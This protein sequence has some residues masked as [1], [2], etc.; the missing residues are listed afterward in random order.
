[1]TNHDEINWGILQSLLYDEDKWILS[2]L[3]H[4]KMPTLRC[5][6]TLQSSNPKITNAYHAYLR[7]IVLCV[8]NMRSN[9][10]EAFL[11]NIIFIDTGETVIIISFFSFKSDT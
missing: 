8:Q 11:G 2:L 7:I 6:L 5:R 9:C 3:P 10:I 4:S 1:M